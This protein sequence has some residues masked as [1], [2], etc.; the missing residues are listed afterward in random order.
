M[1]IKPLQRRHPVESS[2]VHKYVHSR[3]DTMEYFGFLDNIT[4]HFN[5]QI[6]LT[7]GIDDQQRVSNHIKPER[8][9]T[10]WKNP[11]SS[12]MLV[13]NIKPCMSQY[14]P[15]VTFFYWDLWQFF[16]M[17]FLVAQGI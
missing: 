17:M 13:S 5:R 11:A 10:P 1:F 6:F 4:C 2:K 12:H 14:P 8:I 7:I 15:L 16:S 9:K 3:T